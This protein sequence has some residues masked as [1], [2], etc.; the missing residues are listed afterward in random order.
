MNNIICGFAI[1]G[2]SQAEYLHILR[3][4][5]QVMSPIMFPIMSGAAQPVCTGGAINTG[6]VSYANYLFA[7]ILGKHWLLGQLH[8]H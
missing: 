3:S 2:A 7:G 4:F 1:A 6:D 8:H 5:D